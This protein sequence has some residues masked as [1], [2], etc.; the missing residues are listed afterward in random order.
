MAFLALFFSLLAHANQVP[1]HQL[2]FGNN[3]G[4]GWS[5]SS[6][7]ANETAFDIDDFS[8]ETNN[9]SLNYAYRVGERWQ[10]GAAMQMLSD[11][12]E[13]KL[14]GG[15]VET[16]VRQSHYFLFA[17]YNFHHQIQRA[18]YLTAL[19]GRQHF[20]HASNDKRIMVETD[21]EYDLTTYGVSIGKRWLMRSFDG[22]HVTFAPN[23]TYYYGDAS[24]DLG[25]DGIENLR[26]VRVDVIRFDILL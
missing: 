3:L 17:T 2:T 11:E 9:F 13:M 21:L 12:Q 5:A 7:V 6:T 15:E 26:F 18:W 10:L 22:A 16:E 25:H 19:I 8:I 14:A 1:R 24:G 23:I 20:E 4:I